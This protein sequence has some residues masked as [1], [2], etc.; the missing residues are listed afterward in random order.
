MGLVELR[1]RLS[2][3]TRPDVAT[4]MHSVQ[5]VDPAIADSN[6]AEAVRLMAL[7]LEIVR[8]SGLERLPYRHQAHIL[9]LDVLE[10]REYLDA[11]LNEIGVQASAAILIIETRRRWP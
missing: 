8:P 10:V 6:G 7:A 1:S 11:T 5:N 3:E 9:G 4:G 2:E